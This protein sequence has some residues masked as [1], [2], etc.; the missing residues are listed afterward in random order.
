MHC[1]CPLK[2]VACIDLSSKR[3]LLTS[4]LSSTWLLY[5]RMYISVAREKGKALQQHIGLI[6]ISVYQY[7]IKE[8]CHSCT[9]P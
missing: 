5:E 6:F 3:Q 7:S 9:V 4:A 2:M 1:A 8:Y